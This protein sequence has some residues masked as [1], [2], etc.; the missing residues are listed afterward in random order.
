MNICRGMRAKQRLND[1]PQRLLTVWPLIYRRNGGV[2]L[3]VLHRDA[4]P[5]EGQDVVLRNIK[6]VPSDDKINSTSFSHLHL[7][8]HRVLIIKLLLLLFI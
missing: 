6:P 4:D 5:A 2:P 7:Q 1:L 3:L 8:H